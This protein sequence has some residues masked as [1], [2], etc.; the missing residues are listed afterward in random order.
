MSLKF[1]KKVLAGEKKLY[2]KNQILEI[3]RTKLPKVKRKVC[4]GS[5]LGK[6]RTIEDGN[7]QVFP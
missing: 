5:Y 4:V 2:S 1:G 3:T 6:A 7:P